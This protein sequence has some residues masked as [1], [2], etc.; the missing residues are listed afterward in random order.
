MIDI[1]PYTKKEY[2]SPRDGSNT[3][4]HRKSPRIIEK[5]RVPNAGPRAA[6]Q[7]ISEI[8]S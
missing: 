5:N 2:V 4:V 7:A 6:S 1:P 3:S 8:K